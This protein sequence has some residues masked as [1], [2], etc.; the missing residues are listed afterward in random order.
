[1]LIGLQPIALLIITGIMERRI[2]A[3]NSII[4]LLYTSSFEQVKG[5]MQQ[6]RDKGIRFALD[7]FGTGYS[8]PVSYTHLDVYKRQE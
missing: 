3:P 1:M 4:C 2:P 6:L 8:S 5:V 7:D